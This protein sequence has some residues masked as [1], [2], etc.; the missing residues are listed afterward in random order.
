MGSVGCAQGNGVDDFS[1][2]GIAA[3]ESLVCS[4]D[5]MHRMG[6]EEEALQESGLPAVFCSILSL[7]PRSCS[8]PALLLCLLCCLQQLQVGWVPPS[9]GH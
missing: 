5:E 8:F 1:L 4:R 9:L 6:L 3:F 2:M 7:V